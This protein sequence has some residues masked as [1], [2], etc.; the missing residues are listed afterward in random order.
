MSIIEKLTEGIVRRD[1]A[2]EGQALLDKW[3]A[4]GL[5]EGIETENGKHNM[6]QVMRVRILRFIKLMKKS[7]GQNTQ[8]GVQPL[9]VMANMGQETGIQVHLLMSMVTQ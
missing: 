7:T 6:A 4:T 2:A 5:L 8:A 9:E 1:M 3:S